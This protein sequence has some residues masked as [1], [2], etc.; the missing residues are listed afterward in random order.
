M[1]K[2]KPFIFKPCKP[3][4]WFGNYNI[5]Y[6]KATVF[7]IRFNPEKRAFWPLVE[8]K[9]FGDTLVC[10]ACDDYNIIKLTESVNKAKKIMANIPGGAFVINEFGQVIVPSGDGNGKRLLVGEVDGVMLLENPLDGSFIDLSDD[11]ELQ[12]GDVWEKP[13][14]GVKYNLSKRSNIY[15]YDKTRD[16]VIYPV[17]QDK[18]LI[19]KLRKVRRYGSARFIV[20]QHGIVLTKIPEGEYRENDDQWKSVYV[21]RINYNLWFKKEE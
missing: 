17:I 15:Y 12:V 11:E 5:V 1:K 21:G 4:P 19:S 3:K 16:K 18:T 6:G 20:N 9:Y 8:W 14:L 2:T 7:R 13:Y 10:T